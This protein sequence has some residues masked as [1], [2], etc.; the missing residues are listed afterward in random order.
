MRVER[1]SDTWG[2]A[3]QFHCRLYR[4][5]ISVLRPVRNL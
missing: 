4:D 3:G 5:Q 1:Q 2:E